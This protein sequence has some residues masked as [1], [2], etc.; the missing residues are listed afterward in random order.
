YLG[1]DLSMALGTGAAC[2]IIL[3]VFLAT[4]ANLG[5]YREG[6]DRRFE[7]GPFV[8]AVTCVLLVVP[9]A[10]VANYFQTTDLARFLKTLPLLLLLL[11]GGVA[12]GHTLLRATDSEIGWAL[13]L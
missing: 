6:A 10:A 2:A 4:Q 7:W 3:S 13:A 5:R 9:H 11:G 8:F 12:F 1:A